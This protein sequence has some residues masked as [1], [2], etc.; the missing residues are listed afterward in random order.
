[1]AQDR[2]SE[3]GEEA[4]DEVQPRTMLGR[5]GEREASRWSSVEPSS[6]FS[7]YVGGMIIEDQL[8]R[9]AGRISSVETLE[10]FDELSAAVAVS[11]ERMNLPGKQVDSG[12][13]AK[14]AMTFV[15]VIPREGRVDAGLGRQ[16]GCRRCDGLDSRLFVVGDDRH[17]LDGFARLGGSLFQNLDLAVDAQNLR[18]LLL[19]FGIA[20]F[21]IVAHLV[22]LDFLV[23]EN[24]THST[25]AHPGGN[26]TGL[27]LAATDQS[28]KR[29]QL[30]KQLAPETIRV[31]VIWN[32]TASGHHFQMKE[33]VPAAPQLG[34]VLQSYPVLSADNIDAALKA[35]EK[36]DAQ[37]L[38]VME[39]PMI[40][41][42]RASIAEFALQKHWPA[43]GEFRPIVD[44][45]GLMS[46]GPDNVD[47]WRRAAGYVDK[48]LKGANPGDLPVEQPIKFDFVLNLKTAKAIRVI[49]PP[50]LLASADEVIE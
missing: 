9:G 11:D 28:T 1:V 47:M 40:Q 17:S 6:C 23:A 19:K 44:A 12:Q 22:W 20:T 18:H 49:V 43:I 36:A 2:A 30:I 21:Q 8:D 41:S 35:A 14:R 50:A 4:L 32:N 15:L 27:T 37:A 45:G 26:I 48:I 33:L 25:L 46:Y 10:E 3:L 29:L 24:L 42:N 7:R 31:A 34:I 38:F 13:Q 5:E 16:I 39:D